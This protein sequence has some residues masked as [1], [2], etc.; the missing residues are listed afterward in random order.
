MGRKAKHP[1]FVKSLQ[2]IAKVTPSEKHK[3]VRRARRYK[4]TQSE[5]LRA[6]EGFAS[7]H[8]KLFAVYVRN[9]RG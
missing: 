8:E 3:M 2:F 6:C 5:Y 7:I 9:V 1:D 4:M